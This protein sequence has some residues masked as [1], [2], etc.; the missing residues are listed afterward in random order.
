MGRVQHYLAKDH[1]RLDDLL[2]R[3][4]D[5]QDG[6]DHNVYRKFRRG[7]LRHVAME[8]KVLFPTIQRLR[9]GTP[10]P[11]T[12]KLRLDH[13][14]LGAL[15]MPTPTRAIIELIRTILDAHNSLEEG[16]EGVYEQCELVTGIED[17]DLLKRLQAVPPVSVS[18]SDYSDSPAV[19]ATIRRVLMRAGYPTEVTRFDQKGK[20]QG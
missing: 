10:L 6:I 19:F 7:L 9:G 12:A 18:V 5:E 15:I 14:A 1:A 16:P 11:L 2:Q 4:I 17:E 13:G 20:P 3:A 8:E